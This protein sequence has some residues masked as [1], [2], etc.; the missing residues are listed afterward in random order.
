MGKR[1]FYQDE[2]MKRYIYIFGV[3]LVLSVVVFLTIF[4]MYNKKVKKEA[5]MAIENLGVIEDIVSNDNLEETSST[6][7][8][9]IKD[10]K[11]N[12]VSKENISSKT[13]KKVNKTPVASTVTNTE[14]KK[15]TKVENNTANIINNVVGNEIS[16]TISNITENV[17]EYPA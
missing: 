1:N 5:S 9:G 13:N 15:D 14:N 11:N 16:N 8:L 6:S 12:T 3:T 7:D 10:K 2:K 17:T 4:V